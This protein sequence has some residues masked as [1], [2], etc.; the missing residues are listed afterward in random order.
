MSFEAKTYS[1]ERHNEMSATLRW[2][3]GMPNCNFGST[4]GISWRQGQH[5]PSKTLFKCYGKDDIEVPIQSWATA[6]WPDGTIKWT[7]HA[8]SPIGTPNEDYE[9][10]AT[11]IV[12]GDHSVDERAHNGKIAEISVSEDPTQD[13]IT[14]QTGKITVC[15]STRGNTPVHSISSVNEKFRARNGRLVLF[16]QSAPSGEPTDI[17]PKQEM[18]EGR[19]EKAIV[20]QSGPIR[21]VIALKGRHHGTNEGG[22]K[23]WLPFTLRFYLYADS[24]CIRMMHTF[25]YDGDMETDFIRGIGVRFDVPLQADS[26]YDRHIRISGVDGGVLSEAVQSITG[27]R[28]DTGLNVR[29]AQISGKPTPPTSDWDTT[30]SSRLHWV[31]SWNDWILTQLS[32]DGFTVRKRTKAGC[33]WMNIPGGNRSDDFWERYPTGLD[34]GDASSDEGIITMWLYSPSAPAMDLRQYHD[35]LGQDTYDQQLDA[36]NITYEDWEPGLGTPYGIARTNELH[37]FSFDETPD[38]KTFS[39]L[40]QFIRKPP[41]LLPDS[42]TV[43]RTKAL[44]DT[45]CP[46][47][48][49]TPSPVA[50]IIEDHLAFL[51]DFHKSQISQRR[52]Y[53]F[54]DHGDIMH[55]YDEDRH[56]WRYDIGGYAWDNSE[57]SPDLWLWLYFLQSGR[58]NVFRMAESLTRHTGEVD[59]YHLGPHKGLGTRHGVQHWSDSCKQARIS[60]ALYRKYFF[61]LSGGDERVGELL[62]EC[63]ATEQAI[64]TL[65]PY[66]KVRKDKETYRPDATAILI[67]LGTDWSALAA[68]WLIEFERRGPRWEEAKKRLLA[69]TRGIGSLTNGF[70]LDNK[71]VVQISHL[72]AMFGLVEVCAEIIDKF[73]PEAIPGFENAWLEYCAYF[74]GTNTEQISRFGVG[75][76]KLQLRQGHS[77]L[78]AYAAKRLGDQVLAKRAWEQFYLKGGHGPEDGYG[79]DTNWEGIAVSTENAIVPVTEATWVSTNISALYGIAAIQNL[80]LIGY[81]QEHQ[82]ANG[83]GAVALDAKAVVEE[84]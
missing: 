9:V 63:L 44:G 68:A 71:G 52:W 26:F 69:G 80:A 17:S 49:M 67:S 61:Y 29:Q 35:G 64:L 15:F 62:Q 4:F 8:I 84:A 81:Y 34:I 22:H 1:R 38:Q 42:K 40:S 54:W 19:I 47:S 59:V 60:N 30:V 2:L 58:A 53:G 73:P 10:R 77:R 37:I 7:G 57:L 46:Q 28:R 70:D 78:T 11:T 82:D 39:E 75:F 56:N 76:G 16:S 74:N 66:R 32:P 5:Q 25:I 65:D 50:K 51:F 21:A 83:S 33:S 24:A 20:E 23:P 6:Y 18:F 27:L 13:A 72:S 79:P 36:L 45:W 3:E 41:I 43:Y 12:N 55:A 14:V 48:L 31:P